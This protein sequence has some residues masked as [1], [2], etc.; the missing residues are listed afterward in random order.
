MSTEIISSSLF[1]AVR[2]KAQKGT[3]GQKNTFFG[4]IFCFKK[5]EPLRNYCFAWARLGT[6]GV[7]FTMQLEPPKTVAVRDC[8]ALRL[9]WPELHCG[10]VGLNYMVGLWGSTA[11][12]QCATELQGGSAGLNFTV[13]SVG[14]HCIGAVWYCTALRQCGAALHCGS[15]G[16][17]CMVAAWDCPAWRQYGVEL[18]CVSVGVQ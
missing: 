2:K 13:A 8:T 3:H 9:R 16:L 18:H 5:T 17:H 6:L 4:L 12:W 10:S 11:L 15:V 7:I 1:L 14:M